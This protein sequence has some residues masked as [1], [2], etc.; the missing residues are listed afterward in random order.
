MSINESLEIVKTLYEKYKE[1]PY[2]TG[3]LDQYIG[4]QLPMIFE[5]I[6]N[7]REESI[8]KC[9]EMINEQEIFSQSFL[10]MHQYYYIQC[11]EKFFFMT[12]YIICIIPKMI[13]Y[14]IYRRPY[15]KSEH[16]YSGNSERRLIL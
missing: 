11:T 15:R 5:N 4:V 2:I 6:K 8:R 14:T 7:A 9:R 16:C 1:D 3:K 12:G 13:F 10:N